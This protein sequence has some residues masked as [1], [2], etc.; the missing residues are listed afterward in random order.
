MELKMEIQDLLASLQQQ[1]NDALNL[2]AQLVAEKAALTRE[3]EAAPAF[4]S[5]DTDKKLAKK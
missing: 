3:L 4:V 1:R 2:C 5:E